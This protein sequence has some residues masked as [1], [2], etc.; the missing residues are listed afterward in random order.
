MDPDKKKAKSSST[1]AKPPKSAK[2]KD[3]ETA[4]ADQKPEGESI[5]IPLGISGVLPA[6]DLEG[7]LIPSVKLE[8]ESAPSTAREMLAA[9]DSLTVSW[10][11]KG[12]AANLHDVVWPAQLS[13]VVY[14]KPRQD[15]S[16]VAD[17]K[18]EPNMSTAQ[19]N[20]STT[21]DMSTP[22]ENMS[23]VQ[24]STQPAK[25]EVVLRTT[26]V[27]GPTVVKIDG[28][29]SFEVLVDNKAPVLDFIAAG[30]V[31]NEQVG[32]SLTLVKP[33]GAAVQKNSEKLDFNLGCTIAVETQPESGLRLGDIATYSATAMHNLLKQVPLEF[34]IVEQDAKDGKGTGDKIALT[35]RFDHG[36]MSKV[37]WTI[38]FAD[39]DGSWAK[40]S[41]S[42]ESEEGDFEYGWELHAKAPTTGRWG[43]IL[44]SE[45]S[46]VVKKPVLKDFHV[47]ANNPAQGDWTVAGEIE[48]FRDHEPRV[49]IALALVDSAHHCYPADPARATQVVLDKNGKFE[50]PLNG[51]K[52]AL[53]P[54]GTTP[55][56]EAFAI[57]SLVATWDGK[58]GQ[59]PI[60]GFLSY[61]EDTFALF[62]PKASTATTSWEMSCAWIASVESGGIAPRGPKPKEG[63]VGHIPAPGPEAGGDQKSDL[64]LDEVVLD[65]IA[66]EGE[67]PHL[68][69]DSKG[70][71]TIGIGT[72]LVSKDH[73]KDPARTLKLPLRKVAADKFAEDSDP[74]ADDDTK[75]EVFGKIVVM[76]PK[77]TAADYKTQPRLALKREDVHAMVRTF[78]D[79]KAW[80]AL[81]RNFPDYK[82]FPKC[83][84]RAMIDILY[85]AGPGFLDAGTPKNPPKAPK[86]REAILAK[87]WKTAAKE[88][89]V[90]GRAER[91]QW[92]IDLF[93]YA[94]TLKD[95]Q[96]ERVS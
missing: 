3:R 16:T 71:M 24:G 72:C 10:P 83:A 38:G 7:T 67:I 74:L 1:S 96:Q 34:R 57:L 20:M 93:N 53:G 65:L 62:D 14:A 35:R 41:Y 89:P 82:E 75:R 79:E 81:K 39:A 68:Y 45:T 15:T 8:F 88:V 70:Y 86:M 11:I 66:W 50:K 31:G 76:A 29:G 40:F 23:P 95:R 19:D 5:E 21:S 52:I 77:M 44:T 13:W 64:T 80:P 78:L 43:R 17:T 9:P 91:R 6:D 36:G 26:T 54:D 84:R 56:A 61:D 51:P 4:K 59:N 49:R 87:D 27:D 94:Q 92:R 55:S 32:F 12:K 58:G 47:H 42:E 46:L 90:K 28:S 48:G 2:S 63:G 60:S 18:T 25:E 22:E 69:L 37:K 33:P 85:N 30:L 73:A